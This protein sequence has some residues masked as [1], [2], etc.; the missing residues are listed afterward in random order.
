[1]FLDEGPTLRLAPVRSDAGACIVA[2][3]V[4][5]SLERPA[6]PGDIA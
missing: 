3:L 2:F 5:L 1:M 6:D 4:C